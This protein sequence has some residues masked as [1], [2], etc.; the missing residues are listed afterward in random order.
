MAIYRSISSKRNQNFKSTTTSLKIHALIASYLGRANLFKR[1][2]KIH[3][4]FKGKWTKYEIV[5]F[6]QKQFIMGCQLG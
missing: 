2:L 1:L 3:E 6:Y 4:K 5:S